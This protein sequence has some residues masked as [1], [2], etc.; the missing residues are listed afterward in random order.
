MLLQ[1]RYDVDAR[2]KREARTLAQ[3]YNL[4]VIHLCGKGEA[5]GKSSDGPVEIERFDVLTRDLPG[6]ALLWSL[7]FAELTI[8]IA[9]RAAR[10]RPDAYHAHDLP[11]VLPALLAARI[12]RAPVVYDAHELYSE[13]GMHSP[14]LRRIWRSVDRWVLKRVNRV[15]AVNCSR[16]EV[17]VEDLG[18]PPPF[19]VPNLPIRASL[20]ELPQ[21]DQS[22]LRD[23]VQSIID[24]PRSILLYQGVLAPGRA[25]EEVLE[26]VPKVRTPFIFVLLGHKTAYLEHLLDIVRERG[27]SDHVLHHPGV[28]SDRLSAYTVGADAGLVIYAKTPL[29]NYLCAPNKLFEYCMANVPVI[30]CDLPEVRRVLEEATVGELFDVDSPDSIAAAIDRL[31]GNPDRLR[32]AQEATAVVRERHHWGVARRELER[33]YD[34]MFKQQVGESHSSE[35][36]VRSCVE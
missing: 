27:L 21:K 12:H 4:C 1:N 2:V 34:G 6:N 29:N 9:W 7:K 8:R 25:L 26:A 10:R 36:E 23:F 28:D 17:M 5:P 20:N 18:A 19:I 16:A 14:M 31:L 30:G 11:M 24:G 22:P 15:I 3:R 13:M 32:Q 33:L 35:S